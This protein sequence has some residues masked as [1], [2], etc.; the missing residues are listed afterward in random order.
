MKTAATASLYEI[1]GKRTLQARHVSD[2]AFAEL[3]RVAARFWFTAEEHDDDTVTLRGPS[4]CGIDCRDVGDIDIRLPRDVAKI[5]LLSEVC[6]AMAY[7]TG[8]FKTLDNALDL[9]FV[10]SADRLSDT[11]NRWRAMHSE[12]YRALGETQ[13]KQYGPVAIETPQPQGD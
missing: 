12:T 10:I 7:W 1:S 6:C 4:A 9:P 13:V 3:R 11:S 2:E 8:I 5:R